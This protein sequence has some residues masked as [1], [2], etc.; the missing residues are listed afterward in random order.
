MSQTESATNSNDHWSRNRGCQRRSKKKNLTRNGNMEPRFNRW[1]PPDLV[2]QSVFRQLYCPAYV[3]TY[4]CYFKTPLAMGNVHSTYV[5]GRRVELVCNE[6]KVTSVQFCET[7]CRN[8]YQPVRRQTAY[9]RRNFMAPTDERKC[10]NPFLLWNSGTYKV[11]GTANPVEFAN[12][13]HFW[14]KVLNF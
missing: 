4:K 12:F 11:M 5:I 1:A 8:F 7:S 3:T 6:H 13:C 14:E 9:K 2:S 10:S